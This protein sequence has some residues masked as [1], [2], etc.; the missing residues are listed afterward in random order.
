MWGWTAGQQSGAFGQDIK[1]IYAW[2]KKKKKV[3]FALK[4]MAILVS[5]VHVPLDH[6]PVFTTYKWLSP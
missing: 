3:T 5:S 4:H 6:V 2:P 1:M